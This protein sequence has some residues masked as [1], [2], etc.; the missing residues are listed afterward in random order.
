MAPKVNGASVAGEDW[1]QWRG[2]RGD[3]VSSESGWRSKFEAG[4]PPIR[5]R[6][7]VGIGYAAVSVNGGKL[8]TAGWSDGKDV[9][10]CLNTDT[11][12]RIW[13]HE[14]R[15]P[16][17]EKNHKGGP[18][19]TP[20]VDDGRVYTLSREA[21]LICLDA[22]NGEVK[23]QKK[24]NE[25]YRVDPPRW[26][27]AGSPVVHGDMLLVDVGR[28]I[29]FDKETGRE[30]WK[31][32]NY[33]PAYSTP[34]PFRTG[35]RELL[36]VFPKAGLVILEASTGREVAA[37]Q[38]L[39]SYGVNAATPIVDGNRIFI[40]S[41]YGTGCAMLELTDKGLR[42]VWENKEMRNQMPTCVL[43][44]GHLYGFDDKVLKCLDVK[45]G[46]RVWAQRGLG[47]GALTAAGGKL[48]I[49]SED[50]ELQ[51]VDT[52]PGGVKIEARVKV[53]NESH[54]W[55]MPVLAYGHIYC[56]SPGGELVCLNVRP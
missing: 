6:Q 41:G 34:Q 26:G 37:H 43:M 19:A 49:M 22:Q 51:I 42:V 35:D 14:Y 36:A 29:A 13:T 56:R 1:P 5:W 45:K 46:E 17:F 25:L 53:F 50:G 9:I 40:S 7:K 39:T 33:G 54:C 32:R 30:F 21:L 44:D 15:A 28:I 48:I 55:V 12:E 3:G 38:W 18:A 4:R 52:S 27:F 23:W 2:S 47:Q 8:Y 11:G 31:T 24:L 16:R 10:S 20:A